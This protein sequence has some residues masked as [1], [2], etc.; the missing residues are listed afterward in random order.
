MVKLDDIAAVIE[1]EK[2]GCKTQR[3]TADKNPLLSELH[4]AVQRD[5]IFSPAHQART[6]AF[7]IRSAAHRNSAVLPGLRPEAKLP[8]REARARNPNSQHIFFCA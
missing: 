4:V 5:R 1:E 6:A 7:L 2:T 3:G 8:I